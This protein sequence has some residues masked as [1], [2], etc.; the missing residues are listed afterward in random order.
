MGAFDVLVGEP[1]HF[2]MQ[3]RQFHNLRTRVGAGVTRAGTVVAADASGPFSTEVATSMLTTVH[4]VGIAA[5]L[6]VYRHGIGHRRRTPARVSCQP[7]CP[8]ELTRPARQET[9][10]PACP[11]QRPQVL[12]ETRI[13]EYDVLARAGWPDAHQAPC[14][15]VGVS[16]AAWPPVAIC[17]AAIGH[18]YGPW[19]SARVSRIASRY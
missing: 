11:H 18:S 7:S 1:L 9:S 10:L 8:Q 6:P 12:A 4:N 17:R 15:A 16:P 14:R 19:A 13:G 5:A 3:A 2:I